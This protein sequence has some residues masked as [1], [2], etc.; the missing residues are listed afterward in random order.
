MT[1][2]ELKE[3]LSNYADDVVVKTTID[4][5]NTWADGEIY[6]ANDNGNGDNVLWLNVNCHNVIARIEEE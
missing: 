5:K 6:S 1:V 2:K 4:F 3:I